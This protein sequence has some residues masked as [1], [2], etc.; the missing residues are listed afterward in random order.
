MSIFGFTP[1]ELG[2]WLER[3]GVK[4]VHAQALFKGLHKQLDERIWER[5]GFEEPLK[6]W[7]AA[8]QPEGELVDPVEISGETESGDGWT[9]KFL[10]KLGDGRE[11][12]SVLM[13]FPGR[14]TACLSSQVGCAMGCVFCATGQMG[15]GRHLTAAEIV[16]QART[17][18]RMV[19]ERHGERVRNLVMMGMG[20]PLHNFEA[21]M[22]A[23]EVITDTRG[24]NI[25][26]SRVS[27]S[28]VG[29]VPGILKLARQPKRYTLL[30][31]LHGASDEERE[32]LVP[33]NKRW[34]LA[35]LLEAMR[36]YS[37]IKKARV[38]VAWTLIREVNDNVDQ[39]RRLAGL[40]KGMNVHVNLI[41]LNG[42]D[43][44]GGEAPDEGRV[45]AFHSVLKE[46]GLPSTVRQRRGID[47]GAGCGQL[48]GRG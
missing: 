10:M 31:S 26:A 20:E 36:E 4:R 18:E 15:F 33:I 3:D 37:A 11:V 47:V 2:A 46:A 14:F 9:R 13:G 39:A 40:L 48:A 27:L 17:V 34:P 43:G 41:P 25:G 7:L 38:F 12:E 32:A 5:E 23:L 8:R 6:R 35:E 24:L 44:Y 45:M 28:T 1:D 19:R 16:G 42:T 29:H 22:Q 21:V 30:V